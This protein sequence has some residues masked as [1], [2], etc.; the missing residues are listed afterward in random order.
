M[1]GLREGSVV[2]SILSLKGPEF[3]PQHPTSGSSQAPVAQLQE[4]PMPL[5]SLHSHVHGCVYPCIHVHMCVC[6]YMSVRIR[7]Y[8]YRHIV[9]K[10]LVDFKKSPGFRLTASSH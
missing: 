7:V 5:A 2:K 10:T 3:G 1:S 4:N 8:I 6:V 9:K